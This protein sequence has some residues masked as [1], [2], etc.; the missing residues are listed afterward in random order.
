MDMGDKAASAGV[1]LSMVLAPTESGVAELSHPAAGLSLSQRKLLS[2]IDGRRPLA[3]F[4]GTDTG[5]TGERLARDGLRLLAL[6]LA[7]TDEPFAAPATIMR[8]FVATGSTLSPTTTGAP[9]PAATLQRQPARRTTARAS[10]RRIPIGLLAGGAAVVI[11]VIAV[12]VLMLRSPSAPVQAGNSVPYA[13]PQPASA[14]VA[15]IPAPVAA[16]PARAANPPPATVAPPPAPAAAVEPRTVAESAPAPRTPEPRAAAAPQKPAVTVERAPAPTPE[17][18][19]RSNV[20][21]TERESRSIVAPTERTKP[22]TP[23]VTL[24]APPPRAEPER[25]AASPQPAPERSAP[26]EA[27]QPAPVAPIAAAPSTTARPAPSPAPSGPR[28]LLPQER[29]FGA[30]L[31]DSDLVARQAAGLAPLQRTPPIYPRAAIKEGITEGAVRVRLT[32][33]A[34]GSVEKVDTSVSDPRYRVFESAA[35]AAAMTWT[36]VPGAGGRTHESVVQFRA[37]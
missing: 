23:A 33:A 5:L 13:A 3:S 1:P 8:P 7:Q 18:E 9:P 28:A 11:A 32:I 2:K 21:P 19:L 14:P 36:F 17:R 27:A 24:A 6:G 10:K 26:I 16:A 12:G 29:E 4:V 25:P 15:A 35:R 22:Q 37:P 31:G 30:V 34:D 20:A